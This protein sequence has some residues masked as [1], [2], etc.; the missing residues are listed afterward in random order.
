MSAMSSRR[1]AM[2]YRVTCSPTRSQI[3]R[4]SS[5]SLFSGVNVTGVPA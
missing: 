2:L 3:N 4:R 5:G 1:V